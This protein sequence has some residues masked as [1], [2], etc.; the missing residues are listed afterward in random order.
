MPKD[1]GS[2]SRNDAKLIAKD[3]VFEVLN[4]N[5]ERLAKTKYHNDFIEEIQKMKA[6]NMPS[7]NGAKDQNNFPRK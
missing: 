1:S 7:T 6:A 2:V 5:D 4:S 3:M